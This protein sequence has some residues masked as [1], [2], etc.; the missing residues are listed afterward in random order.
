[1]IAE[2]LTDRGLFWLKVDIANTYG[3]DKALHEEQVEWFNQNKSTLEALSD[4]ADSPYEFMNAVKV[5]RQHQKG[6]PVKHMMY[7]DCSNQALQIYAV[8]TGCKDTAELCNLSS[9]GKRNDGYTMLADQMNIEMNTNVFN[10]KN[11]KKAFMTTL[12]GKRGAES[13][14]LNDMT[15]QE[16]KQVLEEG[17]TEELMGEAFDHAM[18]TLAPKAM[19]TMAL[20]Q[21]LNNENI[22]VY[23]WTMPDGFR[24]KYDVKRNVS[25]E[26]QR[27][28]A[29]GL[30]FSFS[31]DTKVYGGTKFNA[32]MAPNVI[33]SIDGYLVRR[34]V[35]RFGAIYITT[36]HDAFGTHPNEVDRVRQYYKEEMIAILNSELLEHIMLQIANGRQF[37]HLTKVNTLTKEDILGALYDVA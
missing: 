33:H 2:H 23:N 3:M 37:K 31:A 15:I 14:I 22:G 11:C 18:K 16:H 34:V 13:V 32:G 25:F 21:A 19:E 7:V 17:I 35:T 5:Y 4:E 26:G 12:Y 24:V 1:M 8:L 29:K 28:S 10:R 9:Y 36:I 20:I 27:V 30:T 6:L